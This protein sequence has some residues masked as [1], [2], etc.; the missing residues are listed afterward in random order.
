MDM[1]VSAV[2]AGLLA[3]MAMPGQ[4]IAQTQANPAPAPTPET[5]PE[6][7]PPEVPG[8]AGSPSSGQPAAAAPGQAATAALKP[9]QATDIT[10]AIAGGKLLFELRPRYEYVDQSNKPDQANAVTMRT[11]LGWQTKPY[12]NFSVTLAFLTV[13][14]FGDDSFN[15]N[16]AVTNSPYPTVPDPDGTVVPLLYLDYT[17]LEKTSIKVGRQIAKYNNLRVLGDVNFRQTPQTFEAASVT[18]TVVPNLELYGAYLWRQLTTLQTEK[19]MSTPTFNARW[20]FLPNEFLIGYAQFQDQANT[21]QNT[22]FSDNSNQIL[23]VRLDGGHPFGEKW[24][25][26]YTAEYAKQNPYSGGNQAIDTFYYHLG[27]GG[28]YG[29]FY[30]MLHQEK[31]ASNNGQ[32]GFQTPL[33][34]L[35]IFQGWA[36]QFT[37]T[38]K[39]GLIDTYLNGGAAFFSKK[40]VFYGEYHWFK[41]D[42]GNIDYGHELDLSVAYPLYKGLVGKLEYAAYRT[43]DPTSVTGKPDVTKFWA[44]LTYNF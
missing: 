7:R 16:P 21:G 1:R 44:T 39:Q 33:A 8:A 2:A 10:D 12:Y 3:A 40:L 42:V 9:A 38:P 14:N 29:A 15:S 17:G 13:T 18:T 22:G 4:S 27:L 6:Q 43:G 11:L 23:G 24:K 28:G 26:L 25:L 5:K 31:L 32:Y 20:A 36:D 41:S 34:T 37:T 19:T 35:H 30:G